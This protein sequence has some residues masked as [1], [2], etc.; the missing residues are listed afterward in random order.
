MY[1]LIYKKEKHFNK[2]IFGKKNG[3]QIIESHFFVFEIL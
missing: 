3:S 1:V 2:Y